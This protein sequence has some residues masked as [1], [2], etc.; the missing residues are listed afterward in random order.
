MA[1]EILKRE[2]RK[3]TFEKDH[4]PVEAWVSI[5]YRAGQTAKNAL[6]DMGAV[7]GERMLA[8][9]EKYNENINKKIE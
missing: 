9:L 2:Y 1:V 8:E 7:V 6:P 3:K 5:A 4:K